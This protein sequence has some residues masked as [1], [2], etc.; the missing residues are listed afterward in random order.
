MNLRERKYILVVIGIVVAAPLL[1]WVGRSLYADFALRRAVET[2]HALSCERANEYLNKAVAIYERRVEPY[3]IRT[4]HWCFLHKSQYADG[5]RALDAL[6]QKLHAPLLKGTTLLL[7]ADYLFYQQNLQASLQYAKQALD[8]LTNNHADTATLSEAYRML[9]TASLHLGRLQEART[10]YQRSIELDPQNQYTAWNGLGLAVYRMMGE[11]AS[12][13][14]AAE[15]YF[16][17]SLAI[18]P[19]YLKPLF[20][21]ASL[22]HASA[23]KNILYAERF[24][25]LYEEK[26]R[27]PALEQYPEFVWVLNVRY[28][29]AH[30]YYVM[31]DERS[32]AVYEKAQTMV[33]EHG[34][35][36]LAIEDLQWP[37]RIAEGLEEARRKFGQ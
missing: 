37:W 15:E 34:A 24:L 2:S 9:G 22:R 3:H 26:G 10:A 20:N 16:L 23:S 7:R 32:V 19:T 36:L 31:G 14:A 1:W 13:A 4:V 28:I 33:D 30:S 29:L 5:S 35:E 25:N 21:L 12:A 17:R 8:I 27:L 18:D 11:D 6:E